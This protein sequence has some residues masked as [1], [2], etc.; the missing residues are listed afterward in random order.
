MIEID[1]GKIILS[2]LIYIYVNFIYFRGNYDVYTHNIYCGI[3]IIKELILDAFVVLIEKSACSIR[4]ARLRRM[5][6]EKIRD[7]GFD[8]LSLN[9]GTE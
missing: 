5:R 4:Y 6:T 8:P 7:F 1:E 3:S 9:Q 2:Y